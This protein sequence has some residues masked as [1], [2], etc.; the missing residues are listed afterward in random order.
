ME[1]ARGESCPSGRSRGPAAP[2]ENKLP[3]PGQK[4]FF[5]ST[6]PTTRGRKLRSPGSISPRR[7]WKAEPN[8]VIAACLG[9][10]E[11][12]RA[13]RVAPWANADVPRQ[14][15]FPS[16]VQKPVHIS[17]TSTTRIRKRRSPGS[18]PPRRV[19]K[20]QPNWLIADCLGLME[21]ARGESC[22]SAQRRSPSHSGRIGPHPRTIKLSVSLRLQQPGNVNADFPGL[23]RPAGCGNPN[24]TGRMLIGWGSWSQ[25]A[26]SVL[27]LGPTP[28]SRRTRGG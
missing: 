13:A 20:P 7:V 5:I 27:P 18:I 1:P 21:P 4:S 12:E 26:A 28:R 15:N 22:L 16:S 10:M 11:P 24:P 25:R 23:Y 14:D 2:G 17:T 9:L 6:T 3:S 19:L 8:W